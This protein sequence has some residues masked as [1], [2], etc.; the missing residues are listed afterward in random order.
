MC[1]AHEMYTQA[2]SIYKTL[3]CCCWFSSPLHAATLALFLCTLALG[4]VILMFWLCSVWPN[5]KKAIIYQTSVLS[6][7]ICQKILNREKPKGT[8]VRKTMS[9]I[10]WVFFLL[11]IFVF[12]LRKSVS[13][14]IWV[15]LLLFFFFTGMLWR[16]EK[17]R[18]RLGD[19]DELHGIR[20]HIKVNENCLASMLLHCRIDVLPCLSFTLSFPFTITFSWKGF[21]SICVW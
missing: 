20:I 3:I 5:R 8:W 21:H 2:K 17:E 7:L 13:H 15:P 1:D 6:S 14:L 4:V 11:F 16:W 18:E 19:D 10:D 12:F 9:S